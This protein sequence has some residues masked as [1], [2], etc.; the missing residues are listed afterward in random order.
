DLHCAAAL[1]RRLHR[2]LQEGA[3]ADQDLASE[4]IGLGKKSITVAEQG[5]RPGFVQVGDPRLKIVRVGCEQRVG[6]H[7][8]ANVQRVGRLAPG[9]QRGSGHAGGAADHRQR[10]GGREHNAPTR[11]ADEAASVGH[12]FVRRRGDNGRLPFSVRT[13]SPAAA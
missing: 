1:R 7:E 10:S 5:D 6:E 8:L 11:E 13:R 2:Q 12:H 3:A 9:L 4:R